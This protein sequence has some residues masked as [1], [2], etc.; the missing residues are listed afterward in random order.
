[1]CFWY[2]PDWPAP[3]DK[4]EQMKVTVKTLQQTNFSLEIEPSETVKTI[5]FGFL[6]FYFIYLKILSVKEK[7]GQLESKAS[8]IEK[9]KLIHSGTS[10]R[11]FWNY[12][13]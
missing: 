7:I 8:V 1:M 11:R 2:F 4:K 9:Q 5:N 3:V 10:A 12:N 6:K 13:Y